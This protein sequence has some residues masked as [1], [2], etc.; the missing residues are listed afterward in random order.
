MPLASYQ[1]G[2]QVLR[3]GTL[4]T[5][6]ERDR[7]HEEEESRGKGL[8]AFEGTASSSPD[9]IAQSILIDSAGD[10]VASEFAAVFSHPC[11]LN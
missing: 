7:E 9:K 6:G 10:F 1:I 11:C 8:R 5:K 4:R 3:E 2:W